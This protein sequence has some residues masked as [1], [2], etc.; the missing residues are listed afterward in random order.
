[1][2]SFDIMDAAVTAFEEEERKEAYKAVRRVASAHLPITVESI[3]AMGHTG[4]QQFLRTFARGLA[5]DWKASYD[6]SDEQVAKVEEVMKHYGIH[7]E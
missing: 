6:F 3:D 2:P 4:R 7:I 1:M 5:K